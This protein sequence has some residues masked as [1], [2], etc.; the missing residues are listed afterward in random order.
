MGYK[1]PKWCYPNYNLLITLL[2]K[3]HEP[4]SEAW[5]A[6]ETLE[7][8]ASKSQ[9]REILITR[10]AVARIMKYIYMYMYIHTDARRI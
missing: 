8:T 1:S 3:S 6:L 4:L 2:T 9:G 5:K 7:F 10:E